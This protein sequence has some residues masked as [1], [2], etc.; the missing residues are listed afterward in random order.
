MAGPATV[1]IRSVGEWAYV[2]KRAYLSPFA[3]VEVTGLFTGPDG[4]TLSMPA[5]YDG[6]G[7][8][9]VRFNPRKVGRW[10]LRL[11]SRPH[12]PDFDQT[13]TFEATPNEHRGSLVATP[14]TA[15]GYTYENGEPFF[16][17]GD[18]VYD[19][20]GMDYCGGDVAGFI[21]RRVSQGFNLFRTRLH[22]SYFHPPAGNFEWQTR[23]MWP[24]GGSTT[25]PRFD[26]FN[27]DWFHSVDKSIAAIEASGIG[28]EMIMEAW[29][30]EF[31][32]NH[33]A[34]FTPEW[35]Q[36][37]MRYL[38]ARYDAYNCTYFWTP[39]NEYEYYPNGDWNWRPEADRWQMRIGRWIKETAPHGH[40]IACHNGPRLPPF[41][42]RFRADPE[43][44]ESVMYQ[45]WGA[46]DKEQGWL[47]TGAEDVIQAAFKG[48]TGSRIYAE[49]G[50]ERNPTFENKLPS[51]EFCDRNHTRR[52]AWRGVTQAMGIINGQENSWGP[53][54]L[55]EEDLPGVA[56][57]VVL[58]D[59]LTR[60]V[61][62]DTLERGQELVHGVYAPGH[63]PLALKSKDGKTA[64]VYFPAG[65]VAEINF[66]STSAK[67][68]DPRSGQYQPAQPE[69][70]RYASPEGTDERGHPLDYVL[71]LSN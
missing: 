54:M 5:F 61:P 47:A 35:E 6:D 39:M 3:D 19:L 42:D 13:A 36:L 43:I 41:A 71:V 37:W 44:V 15:W 69:A 7:T 22:V 24:W 46:R 48:W 56:D 12:N 53:W 27:L 4:K 28:L 32:F 66:P 11:T 40:I 8:W 60:D 45:E 64:V 51:H 55:L 34:W 2:S 57:L 38:I 65:G 70:G 25:A 59:F 17:F 21:Q 49:W 29:G 26:L 58:K 52:A 63:K 68:F 23:R 18:T 50:Y 10:T 14:G 33:R 20:F 1:P 16:A 31:P 9:K 67:W 62:F 30:F